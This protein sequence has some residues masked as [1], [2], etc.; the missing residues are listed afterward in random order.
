MKDKLEVTRAG[1]IE[2]IARYSNPFNP[3]IAVGRDIRIGNWESTDPISVI[4]EF[5]AIGNT[6]NKDEKRKYCVAHGTA[7]LI[8]MKLKP[9]IY[10]TS[11]ATYV[12]VRA[13][14]GLSLI[15]YRPSPATRTIN[16][17]RTEIPTGVR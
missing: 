4:L 13:T 16:E 11:I 12:N 14:P 1:V 3:R 7:G 6:S 17:T 15:K 2:S 5:N 8:L 9:I 10:R